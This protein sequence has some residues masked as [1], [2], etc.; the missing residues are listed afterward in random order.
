MVDKV[1]EEAS[2]AKGRADAATGRFD[3]HLTSMSG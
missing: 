2:A 3:D 1:V